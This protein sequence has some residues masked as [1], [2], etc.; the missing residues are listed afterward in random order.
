MQSKDVRNGERQ[1]LVLI[2]TPGLNEWA[3]E[4]VTVPI[5][6]EEHLENRR[7]I[8]RSIDDCDEQMDCS[9]P[10]NKK[11]KAN[12]DVTASTSQS[13][14]VSKEHILNFPIPINDGRS[15]IV[16]VSQI[17]FYFSFLDF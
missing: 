16:K 6:K 3:K 1:I 4:K 15:C 5:S 12:S 11:E 14:V 13:M 7:S 2:S 17:K 10:D 8:K 9:E